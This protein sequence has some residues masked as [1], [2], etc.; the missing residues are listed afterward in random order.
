VREA[1]RARIETDMPQ[2]LG[3]SQATRPSLEVEQ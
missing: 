3:A 2:C 1:A